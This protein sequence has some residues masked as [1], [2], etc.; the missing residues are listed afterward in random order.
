MLIIIFNCINH[1][2]LKHLIIYLN[3][4]SMSSL[5]L[6]LKPFLIYLNSLKN[7]TEFSVYFYLLPLIINYD[8]LIIK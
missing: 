8:E 4:N 3:F 2:I 6:F 1:L 7:I 5:I